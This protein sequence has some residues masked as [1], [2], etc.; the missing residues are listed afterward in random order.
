MSAR[1]DTASRIIAAPAQAIYDAFIDP[2]RQARWLPPT[3]MTARFERFE[4][5]PGGRYRKVLTYADGGAAHPGKSAAD[6]DIAQ[7]RFL[8]LEPASRIVQTADFV[9]DDSAFAGTMTI[10]WT[11]A[12]VADGTRVTVTARDVP[13]GIS[14][15]DHVAGLTS[16]LA[17]LAEFVE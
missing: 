9:A 2:D 3:G 16:T 5:H 12:P 10:E 8:V 11:L 13:T 7:G 1:V 4:P 6:T 15:E 14:A 17:N